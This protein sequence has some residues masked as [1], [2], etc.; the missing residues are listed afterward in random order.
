LLHPFTDRLLDKWLAEM[1][2]AEKKRNEKLN[3]KTK[4][5]PIRGIRSTQFRRR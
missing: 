3:R 1:D 5:K 2:K 4:V